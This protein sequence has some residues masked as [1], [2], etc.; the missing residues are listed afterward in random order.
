[1]LRR[2]LSAER[3]PLDLVAINDIADPEDIAYLV[4]YDSVHGRL[5]VPVHVDRDSLV[6]GDRRVLIFQESDPAKL[7]WRDND[8]ATVIEATGQFTSRAGAAKHLQAGATR[9]LIG[10]PS[11]DA[12]VTLVLGVNE[13][14]FD[15]A[16]HQIISNASCTTNSLAPVLKVLDDA[17]GVEQVVATTVHA[18]TAS[19]GIVD[20]PAKKRHRGRAAAVSMI[21]TSTGADKATALVLPRLAGKI[22][23]IAI[24]VPVPNGSLT[25]ISVRLRESASEETI[26]A[27]LKAASQGTCKGIIGYT[28]E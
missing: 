27:C 10:A 11:P 26:N 17:F 24:R 1:M 4:K 14:D 19:Q 7:P 2:L 8:V 15:P 22:R 18:Y 3:P 16:Q 13:Q 28:D 12:D 6:I 23:V 21:P 25:D 20:K 5:N 9:V